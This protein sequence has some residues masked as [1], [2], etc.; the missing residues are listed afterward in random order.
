MSAVMSHKWVC[1]EF[2]NGAIIRVHMERFVTYD[3]CD[4]YPGPKL[5]VVLGPNGTGKSSLVCAIC[6]GLAGSTTLLGRAKEAGD[7]VKHGYNDATIEIELYQD[8]GSI[9]VKRVISREG[10]KSLWYLN[11]REVSK[12]QVVECI[13]NLN[14]QVDNLCQFLPQVRLLF[15]RCIPDMLIQFSFK[16]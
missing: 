16:L 6:L 5:N 1:G 2:T 4:F 9:A 14:I 3:S 15:I 8:S 7:F 13:R 11:S 10:N 12:K